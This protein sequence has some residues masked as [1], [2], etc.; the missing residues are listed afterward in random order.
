V[1]EINAAPTTTDNAVT[2]RT[3]ATLPSIAVLRHDPVALQQL[4]EDMY[5]GP[6]RPQDFDRIK[7]PADGTLYFTIPTPA[8][9]EHPRIVTGVLLKA[10][11][12]GAYWAKAFSGEGVP[13]D[14]RSEDGKNG[15]GTPGGLCI[16]CPH[17][18]FGDDGSAPA[19]TQSMDV[20][21]FGI[22]ED[23]PSILVVHKMS[24]QV[25]ER[26][27]RRLRKW[28]LALHSAVT[29]LGLEPAKY[30]N[31]FEYTRLTLRTIRLLTPAE[32]AS[33]CAAAAA[34]GVHTGM[35]NVVD[36]VPD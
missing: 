24:V 9:E 20:T 4:I 15:E 23:Q 19:C 7:Q 14:C 35:V 31:G 36:V 16:A 1:K 5:G 25:V 12:K 6:P 3:D 13:P 10:Q 27:A 33:M 29:E 34:Y 21:Y 22:D 17:F 18:G 26:Y 2:L 28:H 8:G 32:Q 30:R 11:R